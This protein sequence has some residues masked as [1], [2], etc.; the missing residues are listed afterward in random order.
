M[1]I[2]TVS[3]DG[4]DSHV[5]A[6]APTTTQHARTRA[7]GSPLPSG[8]GKGREGEEHRQRYEGVEMKG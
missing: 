4:E 3:R 6:G 8:E 5:Q 7:C 2:R 1:H